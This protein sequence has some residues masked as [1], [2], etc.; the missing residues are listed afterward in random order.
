MG[1]IVGVNLFG[2]MG[3]IYG[4]LMLSLFILLVRV[5]LDEFVTNT[6]N[7][8]TSTAENVTV[9]PAKDVT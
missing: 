2:F 5:Y 8:T 9:D 1:I 3:L 6:A 7:P 4:P